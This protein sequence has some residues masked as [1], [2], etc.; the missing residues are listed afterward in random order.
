VTSELDDLAN[1]FGSDKGTRCGSAHGY[2]IVYELLLH[3]YRYQ[4]I[5]LLELGLSRAGQA[6]GE[7]ADGR[8]QNLPSVDM[9]KAYFPCATVYGFDICDYSRFEGPRF[10]F[11]RGDG[12]CAADLGRLSTLGVSFDVIIDDASHASYHQLLAF[13]L[14]FEV[15]KPGGLYI[16]E[17]LHWQPRGSAHE[18]PAT[19]TMARVLER[20]AYGAPLT[21]LPVDIS[22]VLRDICS[23]TTYDRRS[24]ERLKRFQRIRD[25]RCGEPLSWERQPRRFLRRLVG[26]DGPTKLA[27]LQKLSASVDGS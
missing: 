5:N 23:I 11:V 12:G 24:L 1:Q 15:L 19:K 27:V 18:L 22:H 17:D 25:C 21:Q 16:I 6:S 20:I 7:S 26:R 13:S 8:V 3:A 2:T 10:R 14:L 4:P 9:W